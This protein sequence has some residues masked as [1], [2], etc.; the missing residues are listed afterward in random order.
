[1]HS[2][3]QGYLILSAANGPLQS[4]RKNAAN[5]FIAFLLK[6]VYGLNSRIAL[7]QPNILLTLGE[8]RIKY[9]QKQI[10]KRRQIF[11]I[12]SGQGSHTG[13]QRV[14]AAGTLLTNFNRFYFYGTDER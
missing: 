1:M 6:R 10:K 5:N 7:K 4:N 9:E 8:I 14:Q 3:T 13:G 2:R 11:L 12:H